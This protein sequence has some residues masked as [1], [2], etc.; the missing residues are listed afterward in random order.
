MTVEVHPHL[1]P[2]LLVSDPRMSSASTKHPPWFHIPRL[3]NNNFH[4]AHKCT[5][6]PCSSRPL[7]IHRTVSFVG[8]LRP[9]GLCTLLGNVNRGSV[10]FGCTLLVHLGWPDRW[11]ECQ[12]LL[13]RPTCGKGQGLGQA[14]KSKVGAYRFFPKSHPLP[15]TVL[16]TSGSQVGVG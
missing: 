13:S 14:T 10:H 3:Y 7:D 9:L 15:L 11:W 1:P 12:S 2:S 8:L 5:P 16:A 4:V 6:V